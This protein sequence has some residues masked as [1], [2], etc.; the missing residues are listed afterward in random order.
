MNK[1]KFS[2]ILFFSFF[3]IFF[4]PAYNN[5]KEILIYA[6]SISYDENEN[7]IARGNAKIF[8]ENQII[9]SDLIIYDK[10]AEKILLP[11]KFTLKDDKNNFYE[12][13]SGF[14]FK[15]LNSSNKIL[16]LN[17]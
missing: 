7:I 9:I 11:T 13:E 1:Q 17:F 3:F 14:F 5:A 12:G 16:E 4:I 10:N 6:D 15:N 2:V 8:Q